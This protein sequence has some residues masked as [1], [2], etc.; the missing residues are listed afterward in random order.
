M[1][2]K[3]AVEAPAMVQGEPSYTALRAKVNEDGP[4]LM[5]RT[6]GGNIH[7]N[8]LGACAAASASL[9]PKRLRWP[10]LH[11]V[12]PGIIEGEE[13][14]ARGLHAIIPCIL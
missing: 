3:T 11:D 5:L 10:N 13:V 4:R 2:M 9:Q 8:T 12:A 14:F 6:S 1:P 7:V